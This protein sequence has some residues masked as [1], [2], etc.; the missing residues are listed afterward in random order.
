MCFCCLMFAITALLTGLKSSDTE[1]E[2]KLNSWVITFIWESF[3]ICAMGALIHKWLANSIHCLALALRFACMWSFMKWCSV[4][5]YIISNCNFIELYSDSLVYACYVQTLN[6][7]A[8]ITIF[9]QGLGHSPFSPTHS[10]IRKIWEWMFNSCQ[11]QASQW[12]ARS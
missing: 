1:S 12:L 11:C 4:Y 3:S 10:R 8:G 7:S 2:V 9:F 5:F 6:L